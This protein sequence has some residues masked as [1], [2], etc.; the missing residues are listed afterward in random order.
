MNYLIINEEDNVGIALDRLSKGENIAVKGIKIKISEDIPKGHKFSLKF[1]NEGENIIKYGYPIGK[2]VKDLEPGVWA[3]SHNLKTNLEDDESF[4][5]EPEFFEISEAGERKIWAYERDSGEV[6]IRNEIWIIPTVGCVNGIARQ[7][8][9]EASLRLPKGIDG[10]YA[11]EHPFGCSQMSQDQTNTQMILARMMEHPNAGAVL[12]LGLGCEN[13]HFNEISKYLE[14]ESRERIAY[15]EC[16]AFGDYYQR[17]LEQLQHLIKYSLKFKRKELS[18]SRLVVGLKCGGSDGFSG[19]TANPLVGLVTDKLV[20]IGASTILSEIPEMFGAERELLKRSANREV[21]DGM[22]SLINEYKEYYRQ[23]NQVI[24][25]NPSPGNKEGGITTLEEK[26]LGCIQKGGM[27][28]ISDIIGYGGK[29]R[30][31]GLTVLSSPG[32]DI[33]STTAMAAAGAHMIL[34]TTG[35]GTPLG[36]PVPT[37]K[38]S[39]NNEL[40]NRMHNWNDFNAGRILSGESLEKLAD[41]LYDLIFELASGQQSNS[42]KNG[43]RDFSIFKTGITL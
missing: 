25:D 31:K 12:A 8:A 17:G 26:S 13:C 38:I 40:F 5:Y 1:I 37:I 4:S 35:R 27:S 11:F 20:S 24:Y 36:S 41:E 3:H 39:S 33:V 18:G 7:L 30:N 19:I 15:L 10:I 22:V 32:N 16:Q 42:E 29:V 34:F 21:F 14:K 28:R 9:A 43:Y 6:G 23:H 2:A